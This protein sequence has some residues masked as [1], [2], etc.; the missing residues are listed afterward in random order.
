MRYSKIDLINNKFKDTLKYRSKSFYNILY[1][2]DYFTEYEKLCELRDVIQ[3]RH[4]IKAMR[5][6]TTSKENK[7]LIPNDPEYLISQDLKIKSNSQIHTVTFAEDI[8]S[9]ILYGRHDYLLVDDASLKDYEEPLIYCE[10]HIDGISVIIESY[11]NQI[12][13]EI[14]RKLIAKV[15]HFFPRKKVA[16]VEV[17][18]KLKLGDWILIERKGSSFQQEIMTIEIDHQP[19][20]QC[21]KGLAAIK[22]DK[23]VK[24]NDR[25]FAIRKMD[26][27]TFRGHLI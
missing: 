18:A 1:S 14:T 24:I 25:I 6:V 3:H 27:L 16:V 15:I 21:E 17:Y 4:V 23:K 5:L 19:V 2:S 13:N 22:I 26:N 12:V 20:Q 10:K 7:I 8:T 9:T 11:A